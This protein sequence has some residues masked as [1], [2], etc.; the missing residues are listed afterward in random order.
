MYAELETVPVATTNITQINAIQDFD[1]A[2]NPDQSYFLLYDSNSKK[3]VAV[4]MVVKVKLDPD[5]QQRKFN[6]IYNLVRNREPRFK[7][8]GMLMLLLIQQHLAT[9]IYLSYNNPLLGKYYKEN[10]FKE[11]SYNDYHDGKPFPVLK[12]ARN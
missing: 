3:Y 5:C 1:I 8:S 11:T 6:V 2:Y 4:A 9:D 10:G 12:L 7:G